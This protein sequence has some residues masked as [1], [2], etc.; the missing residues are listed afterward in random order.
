VRRT[1]PDNRRVSALADPPSRAGAPVAAPAPAPATSYERIA[2]AA[3]VGL[4]LFVFLFHLVP[5]LVA[6]LLVFALLSWTAHRLHGPRMSHGVA[7]LV[8]LF[9]VAVVASGLTVALVFLIRGLLHGHAGDLPALYEKMAEALDKARE[10]FGGLAFAPALDSIRD[11]ADL[12]D[13][14]AT[15]LREHAASLKTAGGHFGRF[16]LHTVMGIFVGL[17]VFFGHHGPRDDRPLAAALS[18]RISRFATAFRTIVFAQVEISA[19]NTALTAVYL[20]GVLPLTGHRLPLSGTLVIITF[21]VGLLP[22]VGNLI[23]NSIIVI[24]SLGV[25]PW[26]ALGSLFF[27]IGVHK[28]EYL[29]NARI[30]GS[31]IDASAWEILLAIILFEVA[32]QVPGVVL[33]PVVYAW[34]KRELADRGLV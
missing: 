6:G 23:S 20:F 14:L 32:F 16:L 26:V 33:A 15:W 5:A 27:L 28:L 12:Q 17:L 24:L 22:V 3:A 9:L 13:A 34:G 29:V 19:I 8:A 11:A 31:K 30:V 4:L 7:K 18:E 1:R 21:L 25:G 2:Y 10:R